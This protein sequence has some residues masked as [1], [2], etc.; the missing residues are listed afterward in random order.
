MVEQKKNLLQL[1]EAI[2]I[3]QQLKGYLSC[4]NNKI[5]NH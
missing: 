5:Q 2:K 4:E 3:M 1:Q